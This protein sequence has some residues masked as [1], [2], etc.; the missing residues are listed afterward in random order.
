M[1]KVHRLEGYLVLG[2]ADEDKV[3][4]LHELVSRFKGEFPTNLAL[5]NVFFHGGDQEGEKPL[6]FFDTNDM[7]FHRTRISLHLKAL[8]GLIDL[9]TRPQLIALPKKLIVTPD[10]GGLVYPNGF[11]E[12]MRV[13]T[14]QGLDPLEL[15]AFQRAWLECPEETKKVR[16]YQK[17]LTKAFDEFNQ[18]FILN[19]MNHIGAV[20]VYWEPEG[21]I[22]EEILRTLDSRTCEALDNAYYIKTRV[23]YTEA[24]KLWT[25]LKGLEYGGKFILSEEEDHEFMQEAHAKPLRVGRRRKV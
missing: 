8:E 12:G 24:F 23:L 11:E 18:R 16:E 21:P 7:F 15:E 20:P 19:R 13:R 1:V 5:Q 10:Q 3:R 2:D 22:Q 25:E 17:R 6:T 14:S 9:A 4:K